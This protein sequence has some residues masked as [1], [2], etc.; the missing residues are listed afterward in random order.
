MSLFRKLTE[1]VSKGVSTA[2]EK[3]QQTVEITRL[4]AQLI[5]KRRDIGKLME[6]IGGMVFEGYLSGDLLLE[7]NRMIPACEQIRAIQRE[8]QAME[9]RMMELRNEKECAC[10]KKVPFDARF[11]PSCGTPFP[12]PLA[13]TAEGEDQTA[14]VLQLPEGETPA[15]LPET[16]DDA[17]RED[18]PS[19]SSNTLR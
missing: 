7:K 13:V 11:C 2:T 17:G 6:E 18:D 15:A 10:G 4:H 3:A 5:A 16:P 19:Q 1:T 14:P 9:N 8:I 12:E